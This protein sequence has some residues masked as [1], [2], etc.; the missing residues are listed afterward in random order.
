MEIRIQGADTKKVTA[1]KNKRNDKYSNKIGVLLNY[2]VLPILVLILWEIFVKL[3]ITSEVLLPSIKTVIETFKGEIKSGQLI[4]DLSVSLLRVLK[5]YFI[6][7]L[8]GIILGIIMGI[9]LKA[10]RFFILIITAIRQVPPLAW[11]PLIILWVGIGEAAKII[12][13]INS[14]FLSVLVNTISGIQNTPK[15]YIEVARLHNLNKY[16]LITKV[17]YPSAVPYIFVGLKLGLG[18]SWMTVVAAELIAAS[19]GIGFRINDARA[20]MESDVVIIGILVIGIVGALMDAVLTRI[21]K[22]I[23]RWQY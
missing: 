13:I 3:N 8:L 4:N 15:E 18:A 16:D 22:R 1:K 12:I 21:G 20:L 23:T 6:G 5:G 2:L 14:A 11:I 7:S 19:S 17:Y 9:S 10:N